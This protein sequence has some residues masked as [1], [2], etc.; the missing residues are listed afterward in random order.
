MT[1]SNPATPSPMEGM[2]SPENTRVLDGPVN[3]SSV[4]PATFT[5]DPLESNVSSSSCSN[6]PM[7]PTGAIEQIIARVFAECRQLIAAASPP[8]QRRKTTFTVTPFDGTIESF[9]DWKDHII[10]K[11]KTEGLHHMIE[12]DSVKPDDPARARKWEY[13]DSACSGVLLSSVEKDKRKGVISVLPSKEIPPHSESFKMWKKITNYFKDTGLQK[14]MQLLE[15]WFDI[16]MSSTESLPEFLTRYDHTV[17][18]YDL[19]YVPP[20]SDDM[21]QVRLMKALPSSYKAW[22]R[23]Q[24][25]HPSVDYETMK[26]SLLQYVPEAEKNATAAAFNRKNSRRD[27][28]SQSF[29]KK[30]KKPSQGKEKKATKVPCKNPKCKDTPSHEAS[31]CY[32]LPQ[33]RSKAPPKWLAANNYLLT[34]SEHEEAPVIYTRYDPGHPMYGKKIRLEDSDEDDQMS[35]ALYP[36][37]KSW[38]QTAS[39]SNR[40]KKISFQN[41]PSSPRRLPFRNPLAS[42]Q[43][44]ADQAFPLG[45]GRRQ[46]CPEVRPRKDHP[47]FQTDHHD[48]DESIELDYGDRMDTDTSEN[49][50]NNSLFSHHT[51]PQ[52]CFS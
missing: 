50:S 33:N 47:L 43:W 37:P 19:T 11:L 31:K 48:S 6:E 23:D 24:E 22:K 8:E 21:R 29:Q 46:S 38:A 51:I 34:D 5:I 17:E 39:S 27:E 26:A 49:V 10:R 28:D 4:T 41:P 25:F 20:M 9:H 14:K 44:S 36:T 12:S 45:I 15:A 40:K 18:R 30:K 52:F 2:S 35:S 16:K 13:E 1:S 42:Y 7:L 3:A 32:R